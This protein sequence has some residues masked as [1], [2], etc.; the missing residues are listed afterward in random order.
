MKSPMFLG[1]ATVFGEL[2]WF[3][4]ANL[5]NQISLVVGAATTLVLGYISISQMLDKRKHE[6]RKLDLEDE[7]ARLKAIDEVK[8]ET[9]TGQLAEMSENQEKMRT[10]LH[11]IR[12]ELNARNLENTNLRMDLTK[13]NANFVVISNQL[14]EANRRLLLSNQ[15]QVKTDQSITDLTNQISSVTEG[16]T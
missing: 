3:N 10:S 2:A 12:D 9:L 6:K 13:A 5:T 16:T 7:V 8:K 15:H 14:A 1:V 11:G 4:S